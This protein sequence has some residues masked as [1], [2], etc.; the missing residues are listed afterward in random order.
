MLPYE[1]VAGVVPCEAGWLVAS[2]RALR[3]NF[4]PE[5]PHTIDALVGVLDQRPTMSVIALSAPIGSPAPGLGARSC[6]TQVGALLG[7]R[8][9]L[10]APGAPGLL[11]GETDVVTGSSAWRNQQVGTWCSRYREVAAEMAPFMQ[12]RVYEVCPELSFFELNE[13]RVLD[14]GP[15]SA[16]GEAA[17]RELL[18]AHLPGVERVLDAALPG[19]SVGQLLEVAA[20]LW[21]ARRILAHTATRLPDDPEWDAAGL[22]MEMVR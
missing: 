14:S 13:G 4:A 1:I 11:T 16:A 18:L 21:T 10:R 5:E 17:R 15:A 3:A 6:D 12:R 19:I 2:A 9:A 22:R 20:C 8:G 7:H